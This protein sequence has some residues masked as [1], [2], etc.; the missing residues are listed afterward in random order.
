MAFLTVC[1]VA[2]DVADASGRR[3]W[4]DLS[5]RRRTFSGSLR[6]T[7]TAQKRSWECATPPMASDAAD[8]V[9]ALV[10]GLGHTWR[11]TADAYSSKGLLGTEVGT[12]TYNQAGFADAKAMSLDSTE[13]VDWTP[14]GLDSLTGDY[15]LLVRRDET[16]WQHYVIRSLGGTIDKWK[17]GAT[18]SPAITWMTVTGGVLRLGEAAVSSTVKYADLVALPFAI[19]SSWVASLQTATRA[20]PERPLLEVNGDLVSTPATPIQMRGRVDAEEIAPH[21][22]SDGEQ[23]DGR[24]VNFTLEEV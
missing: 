1:A 8:A 17:N 23:L 5:D 10:R 19:P 15:T 21:V 20:F 7:H 9:S 14:S 22:D 18:H 16:G 4:A 2:V 12:P 13:Y 24:R 11:F 3:N 6:S